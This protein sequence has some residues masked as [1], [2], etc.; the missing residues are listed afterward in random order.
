MSIPSFYHKKGRDFGIFG[1]S[2]LTIV[3][4][5]SFIMPITT[6]TTLTALPSTTIFATIYTSVFLPPAASMPA[7]PW[8]ALITATAFNENTRPPPR[9]TKKKSAPPLP[10]WYF[11]NPLSFSHGDLVEEVISLDGVMWHFLL[12]ILYVRMDH[13]EFTFNS[14]FKQFSY[15]S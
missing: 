11:S 10:F 4:H 2:Y 6:T 12:A 1:M 14:G 3:N 8:F 15:W 7:R 13:V 9:N 5:L